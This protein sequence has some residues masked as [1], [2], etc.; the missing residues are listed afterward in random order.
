M[1]EVTINNVKITSAFK[2][3]SSRKNLQS[4]ATLG[5]LFGQIAKWYED[6]NDC[7]FNGITTIDDLNTIKSITDPSLFANKAAGSI[8]LKELYDIVQQGALPKVVD[9]GDEE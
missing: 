3:A 8:A 4:G 2:N 5:E 9:C 1:S 7:A 6:L